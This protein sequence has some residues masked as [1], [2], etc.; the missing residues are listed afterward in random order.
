M[1]DDAP[2][3][4][5]EALDFLGIHC[6][7]SGVTVMVGLLTVPPC[8]G[9]L[10]EVVAKVVNGCGPGGWKV[11]LVPDTILLLSV[12]ESCNIHDFCYTEGSSE[13]Y[14]L[15]ADDLLH[16]NLKATIFHAADTSWFSRILL[17]HRLIRAEEYYYA[18]RAFGSDPFWVGK[19]QPRE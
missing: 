3:L 4:I 15:W 17:P 16:Q 18:V 12:T 11:D 14:R 10:P 2:T 5:K 1:R 8:T 6:C 7:F 13:D 19:D 9:T